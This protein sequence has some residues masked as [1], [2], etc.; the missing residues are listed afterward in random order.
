M[1]P[2][3]IILM[4]VRRGDP[5][6][7]SVCVATDEDVDVHQFMTAIEAF[8]LAL[9]YGPHWRSALLRALEETDA[10]G[11]PRHRQ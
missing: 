2:N 7:P 9:G 3:R 10:A 1:S 11:R 6:Y 8:A 5:S 4:L